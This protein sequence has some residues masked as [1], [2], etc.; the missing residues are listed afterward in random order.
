MALLIENQAAFLGRVSEMDRVNSERFAR[1]ESNLDA[2]LR[3]LGEHSRLL[4]DHSR[5]F[6]A[7][8]EAIREKMGFKAQSST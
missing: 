2:I 6:E 5:L 1:I 8:P 4:Q 7:L 3:V